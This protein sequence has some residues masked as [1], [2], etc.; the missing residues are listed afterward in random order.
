MATNLL[1]NGDFETG[2]FT[3]W[4][5]TAGAP[6]VVPDTESPFGGSNACDIPDALVILATNTGPAAAVGDQ[7]HASWQMKLVSGVGSI[8]FLIGFVAPYQGGAIIVF[9]DGRVEYRDGDDTSLVLRRISI[10][11]PTQRFTVS[12]SF[13]I[14]RAESRM[15]IGPFQP[16]S[17]LDVSIPAPFNSTANW[18][19]DDFYV[20]TTPQKQGIRRPP[21]GPG[22]SIFQGSHYDDIH[23][24][25]HKRKDITLDFDSRLRTT[26]DVIRRDRDDFAQYTPLRRSF[27]EP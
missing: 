20:G 7:F 13:P 24:T 4:S 2:D 23:G 27:R 22:P 16:A 15:D 6:T 9:T 11:D 1:T 18:I 12:T 25:L 26:E 10:E 8:A 21:N 19:V 17:V 14:T 3:G 5:I